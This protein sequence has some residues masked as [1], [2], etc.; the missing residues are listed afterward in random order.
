MSPTGSAPLGPR[1]LSVERLREC[2]APRYEVEQEIGRGGNAVV[3]RARDVEHGRAVAV[4]V[5]R[6]E[7]A[8]LLGVDRFLREVQIEAQLQHPHIL[9]LYDSG[10]VDGRPYYVT[11]YAAEGSLR[12]CLRR[13]KQLPLD[14]AVRIVEQMADALAHAH[15]R[16]VVHRDVKPEN[17]LFTAGHAVLADFG[18]ARAI[19]VAAGERITQSGIAVGTP[20]YMS[21]EQAAADGAVDARS[22][23]Y[24]LGCVLYEMLAGSPAFDGAT[25]QAILARQLYD[26][27]PSLAILRPKL[28]AG[29]F[30]FLERALEKTPADR[31]QSAADFSVALAAAVRTPGLAAQAAARRRRRIVLAAAAVVA[32]AALVVWW[33]FAPPTLERD[34]VVVFPFTERGVPVAQA[35]L[36]AEVALGILRSLEHAEVMTSLD[37]WDRLDERERADPDRVTARR[38]RA[39]ARDRRARHYIT[40][41]VEGGVDSVAV[42]VRLYDAAADTLVRQASASAPASAAA[43]GQVGETALK[44][45]L[46]ALLDPGSATDIGV[47]GQSQSAAV[48]LWLHGERAYRSSRFRDAL[49]AFS[50]AVALDSSLGVA[51]VRGAQ[52]AA[53]VGQWGRADTLLDYGLAREPTLP[54]Q[55]RL[56]AH[57]LRYYFDGR[58]DSAASWL[59]RLTQRRPEWADGRMA[60][61]EVFYH[62]GASVLGGDSLAAI[63]FRAALAADPRF[64]PALRHV[65]ELAIRA[66]RPDSARKL[67]TRYRKVEPDS[68]VVLPIELMLACVTHGP[69][70]EWQMAAARDPGAVMNAGLQL[71][72]RGAHPACAEAAFRALLAAPDADERT[73]WGGLI[74]LQTLLVATGRP[75]EARA[76]LDSAV[77]AGDSDALSY[78]V[79]GALAGAPMEQGVRQLEALVREAFQDDYRRIVGARYVWLLGVW[80]AHTGDATRLLRALAAIDEKVAQHHAPVDSNL[81][82]ALRAHLALVRRDTTEALRRFRALSVVGPRETFAWSPADPLAVE[83]IRL[84]ELQLATGAFREALR[85][86]SYLDD[87]EPVVYLEFLPMSLA[88]RLAAARRLGDRRLERQLERRLAALG[89]AEP[90]RH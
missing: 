3:Y 35:G 24:A 62:L 13:E 76:L 88:L 23:L 53:W 43:A 64:T 1:P 85:T 10:R 69:G 19:T 52:A 55:Y 74:G 18:L 59:T 25:A 38:A 11:P 15:A 33:P 54:E 46:P 67:L 27:P 70:S 47:L 5:V 80:Y 12:D 16:G 30:R 75:R 82:A 26:Q 61:G 4:K 48:A 6:D 57:G 77:Q 90:N 65:T 21:P 72:G 73:R 83:R 28:P 45:V 49:A 66:D 44:G 29:V 32:T 51:A 56:L 78:Y 22:D 8:V 20:S 50:R 37:G 9:P 84:T 17:I 14:D 71:A 31:W 68:S 40:G 34:R 7:I 81:A 41:V 86:A 58:P 42:S 60:L 2:L 63:E 79:I 39:I 87:P 89:R 36:G